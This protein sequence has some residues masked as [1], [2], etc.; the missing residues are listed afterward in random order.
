MNRHPASHAW[1]T[2]SADNPGLF[3]GSAQGVYLENRIRVAFDVGWFSAL[4]RLNQPYD[5]PTGAATKEE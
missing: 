4:A 1:D 3:E 2:F 5:A